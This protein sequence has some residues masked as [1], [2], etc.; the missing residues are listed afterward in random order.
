MKNGNYEHFYKK[1]WY[2]ELLWRIHK[3]EFFQI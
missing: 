3:Y 2:E 1:H